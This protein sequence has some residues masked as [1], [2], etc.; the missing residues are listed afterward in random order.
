MLA[1]LS[2]LSIWNDRPERVSEEPGPEGDL[3]RGQRN[4]VD[5]N[6]GP[7]D[8]WQ[9]TVDASAGRSKDW[10]PGTGS[11]IVTL[12]DVGE[13][14]PVK[15]LAIISSDSKHTYAYQDLPSGAEQGEFA[16]IPA[17][18][19]WLVSTSSEAN[20]R[21]AYIHRMQVDVV[22]G[23]KAK[24]SMSLQT[25]DL[26][27]TLLEENT[28]RIRSQM[29]IAVLERIDDPSWRHS[30]AELGVPIAGGWRM[31]IPGLAATDYRL[32]I[33]GFEF[34]G[35]E[36]ALVSLPTQASLEINGAWR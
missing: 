33:A 1:F 10:H 27:I 15:G 4:P 5:A 6:L 26:V 24:F 20:A 35:M 3:L 2:G 7:L 30:L 9:D 11:I 29:V 18:S 12:Q 25:H 31:R 32:D 8:R 34:D 21:F 28:S 16:R 13:R 14:G 22:E 17:G 36:K 23:E 19:H